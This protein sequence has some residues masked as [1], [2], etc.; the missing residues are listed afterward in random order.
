MF[1]KLSPTKQS[2]KEQLS[3][4][5]RTPAWRFRF[6]QDAILYTSNRTTFCGF[7]YRLFRELISVTT[8]GDIPCRM[9]QLYCFSS[10]KRN[11]LLILLILLMPDADEANTRG[12]L[13]LRAEVL[14][15]P[16][17]LNLLIAP[18]PPFNAYDT[19]LQTILHIKLTAV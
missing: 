5:Y 16:G 10:R 11:I 14:Q 4:E 18:T 2:H 9:G 12:V 1:S 8:P 7:L 15:L 19:K 3:L 13:G 17:D 6:V